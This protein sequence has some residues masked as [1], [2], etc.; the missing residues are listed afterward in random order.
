MFAVLVRLLHHFVAF[1]SPWLERKT[2]SRQGAA[3]L[4]LSVRFVPHISYFLQLQDMLDVGSLKIKIGRA[5]NNLFSRR[6]FF[7]WIE[8]DLVLYPGSLMHTVLLF[9]VNPL[10]CILHRATGNTH[11]YYFPFGRY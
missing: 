7:Y 8:E 9:L 5:L 10:I 11:H 4:V 2:Q 1:R 6:I 3:R